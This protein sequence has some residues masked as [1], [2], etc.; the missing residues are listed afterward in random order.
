MT[1]E[2]LQTRVMEVVEAHVPS[3]TVKLE[4]TIE[5]LGGD[6]LGLAEMG[7]E[8]EDEFEIVLEEEIDAWNTVADVCDSVAKALVAA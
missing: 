1:P 7:R 8:L 6:A 3:V 4:D 2:E 5:A